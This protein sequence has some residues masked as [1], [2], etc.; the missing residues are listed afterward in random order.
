VNDS[1]VR[2]AQPLTQGEGCGWLYFQNRQP[3]IQAPQQI[4][5]NTRPRTYLEQIIAQFDSPQ[6]PGQQLRRDTA[7]PSFRPTDP[8]MQPVHMMFSKLTA[9]RPA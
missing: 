8:L 7:A 5:C 2:A 6:C 4:R 1:Y 3:T 9:E